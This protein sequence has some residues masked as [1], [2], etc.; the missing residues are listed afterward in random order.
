MFCQLCPPLAKPTVDRHPYKE[1][2][3]HRADGNKGTREPRLPML[4]HKP[5]EWG[6]RANILAR[7]LSVSS[8]PSWGAL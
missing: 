5:E 7:A 1:E 3:G 2:S 4:T 6:L 8:G